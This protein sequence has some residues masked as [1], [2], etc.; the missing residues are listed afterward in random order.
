MNLDRFSPRERTWIGAS[1]RAFARLGE[2]DRED[3]LLRESLASPRRVTDLLHRFA[4]LDLPSPDGTPVSTELTL[5][6]MAT[7]RVV[8]RTTRQQ[9]YDEAFRLET[10]S[11]VPLAT[12]HV[13]SLL[14]RLG[15]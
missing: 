12:T 7:L 5:P 8:L 6:E 9:G 1:L 4:C 10:S 14:I 3:A 2:A 15:G 13:S 11:L